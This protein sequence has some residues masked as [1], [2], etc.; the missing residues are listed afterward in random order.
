LGHDFEQTA[1]RPSRDPR[2]LRQRLQGAAGPHGDLSRN[3]RVY[4]GDTA[5]NTGYYTFSFEKDGATQSL[6]ARYSF[7]LVKRDGDWEI[8]D[9]HSSAMPAAPR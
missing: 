1:G 6:P 7:T 4:G 2:L 9:H 5:V 3:I 8:V